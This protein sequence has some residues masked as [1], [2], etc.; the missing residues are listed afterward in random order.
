MNTGIQRSGGTPY[1]A[2]TTTQPAGK[3]SV[4][5]KTWKKNMAEIMVAHRVPYVATAC[6]SY[7]FD[8]MD[9]VKKAR[10]VN[11]PAFI[12]CLAVCPTG[13]RSSS[14][15]CIKM[16]RLAVETG[17]FPLYE[18]ENGKYKMTIEMPKK[19]RPMEDYLKPQG[20]FRHLTPDQI[21]IFKGMAMLEYNK[22]LERIKHSKSWSEMTS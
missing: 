12:H 18:V 9:K 3:E 1:G 15:T 21:E 22:V 20:R 11:G 16:G 10:K 7:P 8:F 2:S 17:V 6:H 13:W 19:L 4:G 5:N 14:E